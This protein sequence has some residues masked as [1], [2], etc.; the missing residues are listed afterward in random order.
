MLRDVISRHSEWITR[1]YNCDTEVSVDDVVHL[2]DLSDDTV[3]SEIDKRNSIPS[4]GVVLRKINPTKCVV[5]IKG[6]HPNTFS[7][8]SRSKRV[9][10]NTDGNPTTSVPT[11]GYLQVLG[12]CDTS[13]KLFV[14]VNLTRVKRSPF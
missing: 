2:S 10:L 8:L 3:V 6:Y 4:I 14:D 13:D 11:T 5:L 9:Y 12:F 7:G 1:I